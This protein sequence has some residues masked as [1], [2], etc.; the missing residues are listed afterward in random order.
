MMVDEPSAHLDIKYKIQ[1]MEMLRGLAQS[2]LTVIMASHDLNLVTRY[3]D[4]VMLLHDGKI[5]DYG[6]CQDVITERSIEE[7]FGIRIKIIWDSGIPYIIPRPPS[8]DEEG[9][10]IEVE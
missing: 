9:F 2:G 10:K 1:V 8:D 4:K 3:C 6:R 7:V 5:I